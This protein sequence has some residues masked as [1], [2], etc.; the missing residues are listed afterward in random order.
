MFV[1]NLPWSATEEDLNQL[2]SRFG[3]VESI[4]VLRDKFTNRARGFGFVTMSTADEATA[5]VAGTEGLDFQG[6]PLKVNV[7]RP[8]EEGGERPRR[9]FDGPREGG[10]GGGQGGGYQGGA[11]RSG[12]YQGGGAPRSGGYQGGGSSGGYQGGGGSR[13][14]YQGGGQGG[15]RR[16]FGGSRDGGFGGGQGG[17]GYGR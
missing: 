13:G 2:F 1:G 6:R 11:P 5:A 10:F 8:R 4:E 7:A 14:G 17:G 9:S 3:T 15:E 12:G 16:S